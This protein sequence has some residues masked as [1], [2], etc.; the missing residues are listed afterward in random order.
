MPIHAVVVSVVGDSTPD[1]ASV[2]TEMTKLLSPT[3]PDIELSTKEET[4]Q[5]IMTATYVNND[6]DGSLTI[7]EGDDAC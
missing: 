2:I 6:A 1:V 3:T 5:K 4:G 7:L